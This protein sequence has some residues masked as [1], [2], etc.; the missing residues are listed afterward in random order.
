M[1]RDLIL[2]RVRLAIN[3]ITAPRFYE[4]ERGYQGALLAELTRTLPDWAPPNV[5]IE[6]E[7]QKRCGAHG[8]KIRPDIVIHEPFNEAIH[9]SRMEGNFVAFELKLNATATAAFEDFT[10][11]AAMTIEL[12]YPMCIFINI[13]S[14]EPH[15]YC[16]PLN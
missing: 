14:A 11:L 12:N 9:G 2:E 7:Y 8:I 16:A 1:N 5:I 10:S 13:N 4:T 15:A 6:Q 3:G